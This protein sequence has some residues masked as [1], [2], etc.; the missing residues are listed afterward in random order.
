MCG[1]VSR[2]QPMFVVLNLEEKVPADHPLRAIK[3]QAD[4]ILT[5]MRGDLAAAYCSNKGRPGIPPEQLLKA[6]L[7]RA[8]YS[9]RS[10][11]QLMQAI[12][13]YLGTPYQLVIAAG[14]QGRL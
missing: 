12:G 11:I 2:Q 6:M 7:L 10:E 4:A 14:H 1:H 8:L 9:I 5:A 3:S 13:K